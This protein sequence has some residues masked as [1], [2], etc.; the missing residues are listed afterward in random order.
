MSDVKIFL[1]TMGTSGKTQFNPRLYSD[2]P[3]ETCDISTFL[4]V[5]CLFNTQEM[6]PKL[7]Y[8]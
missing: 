7:Y 6:L 4:S 8:T 2:W 5:S 1:Y 3:V